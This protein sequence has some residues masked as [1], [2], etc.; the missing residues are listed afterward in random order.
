VTFF[1]AQGPMRRGVWRLVG[2]GS[3]L[4][5]RFAHQEARRSVQIADTVRAGT[6]G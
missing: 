2:P 6:Q 5:R 4:G 3:T 1:C